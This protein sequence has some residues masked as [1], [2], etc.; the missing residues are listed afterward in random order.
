MKILF[1]LCASIALSTTAFAST[2]DCA[3]LTQAQC[4]RLIQKD[5]EKVVEAMA[6][7][8][9]EFCDG[10]DAGIHREYLGRTIGM[11]SSDPQVALYCSGNSDA[12]WVMAEYDGDAEYRFIYY[13]LGANRD[14][15]EGRQKACAKEQSLAR[16]GVLQN[17]PTHTA[18]HNAA[19]A[20]EEHDP[21]G[22]YAVVNGFNSG[23]ATCYVPRAIHD[24]GNSDPNDRGTP[25]AEAS[26]MRSLSKGDATNALMIPADEP[27]SARAPASSSLG[28]KPGETVAGTILFTFSR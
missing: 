17:Y 19:L 6:A 24:D 12:G 8:N 14:N 18:L 23:V 25:I 9:Q 21:T 22:K 13:P 7:K 16:K 1:S 4:A 11:V 28:T 15:C 27:A 5:Q 10:K 3:G 26:E 2:W 20:G